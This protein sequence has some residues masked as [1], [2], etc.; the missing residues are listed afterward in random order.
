VRPQRRLR[1]A[2]GD[3]VLIETGR[4]TVQ[5]RRAKKPVDIVVKTLVDYNERYPKPHQG[6]KEKARRAKRLV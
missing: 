2:V 4:E 6:E 1:K 3:K 5:H